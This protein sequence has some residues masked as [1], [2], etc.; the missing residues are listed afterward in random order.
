[1][2]YAEIGSKRQIKEIGPDL[3]NCTEITDEK[4]LINQ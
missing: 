4:R 3:E 2:M 1:M